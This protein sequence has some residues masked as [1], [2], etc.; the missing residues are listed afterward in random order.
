MEIGMTRTARTSQGLAGALFDELDKLVNGESTPQMARAK[1]AVA[2]TIVAIS[3]LEID[4]ARFVAQT[5]TKDGRLPAIQM[6][7]IEY[8]GDQQQPQSTNVS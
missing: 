2:G 7:G 8:Q 1:A 6:A 3:R 4:F 5:R